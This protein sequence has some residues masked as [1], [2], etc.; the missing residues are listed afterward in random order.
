MTLTIPGRLPGMNEIIAAAKLRKRNY[1]EYAVMKDKNTE[2][3]AWLAIQS[4]I[5][6]F[7]KAYF[8]ITWYEPDLRRDPDNIMGGQKFIM[9]GLVQAGVIPNDSQKYILGIYHRFMVDRKNPRIEV[10]IRGV[11]DSGALEGQELFD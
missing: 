4:H 8:I 11:K 5:P 9:D 10:E 2:Q 6:R 1:K 3:V 7:E